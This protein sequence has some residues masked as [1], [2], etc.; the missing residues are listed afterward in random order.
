MKR[1]LCL[2]LAVVMLFGIAAMA[3]P[4]SAAS[5][6]DA[7]Y[8][9]L[10]DPCEDVTVDFSAQT[11]PAGTMTYNTA[12]TTAASE[13]E[14]VEWMR[15]LES[16]ESYTKLSASQKLIDVIKDFE[17]FSATA[18]AD[19][20]Q[21]TIGY[22]SYAGDIDDPKPST[23]LT[24]A[25]AEALLIEQLET[26]EDIVNSYCKK[27]GKQPTQNQ[28]D[29]LVDLTYNVGGSWTSGNSVTS[30]LK[31]ACTALELVRGFG[32]YS[33]SG[34]S[35]SYVHCNRRVRE[36]LIF[37]YGEY[38]RAYGGQNCKTGIE[39]VEDHDLPHF[40]V[41]IFKSG[42]GAFSSGKTDYASYYAEDEYYMEF[43]TAS[44]SGYTLTGWKISKVSNDDS[45]VEEYVIGEKISVYDKAEYNLQLTAIWT[46][47]TVEVEPDPMPDDLI[48]DE[49][50]EPEVT[51]QNE[52]PFTD[53]HDGM[54]YYEAVKYVY[55]N[56]LM[57]GTTSTTFEADTT[58][59]RGMLVT[60]LYRMSGSPTVT[61]EQ[62]GCFGDID[63]MY[64]EDAVA[65][66]YTYDIV[67]GTDD[68]TFAPNDN[69]TRQD[70]VTIF[71]RYHVN[72][73]GGD[74][75][76]GDLSRFADEDQVAAYA[77]E[78]MN[79]AVENGILTGSSEPDGLYLLPCEGL[80][81]AQGAALLMRMDKLN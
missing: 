7:A 72:Y 68:S 8:Q 73:L 15:D 3:T 41:V 32:A 39:V 16:G 37:L 54:W 21:W 27:I 53:I 2:A 11:A 52:T 64:Y 49:E 50:E 46:K 42:N 13:D 18:Y 43:A 34:G 80:T 75:C 60:V 17:G 25:Q 77:A 20:T 10:T 9:R 59:T 67:K 71:Y 33:R 6:E 58:M 23:K 61:D 28:F 12:S 31:N 40:K 74:T 69:V 63:G 14:A 30:V 19:N 55:D 38:Y 47:G 22:G 62:R 36:A 4:V 48:E 44:R 26:Y 65:W 70:A 1:I 81:R 35:V 57:N 45:S 76:D 24:E 78:A 51:N 5:D 66:A 56:G 29:A 79:W